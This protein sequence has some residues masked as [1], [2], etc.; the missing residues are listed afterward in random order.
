MAVESVRYCSVQ[1]IKVEKTFL[2]ALLTAGLALQ[3][4]AQ[5]NPAPARFAIVAEDPATRTAGDVLTAEL[6]KRTDLL[7]LE[8]SEIEKVYREQRL[9]AANTDCLKLGRILGADGLLVAAPV[10]EQENKVLELRLIAAKPGVVLTSERFPWPPADLTQWSAGVAGHLGA[11]LAK[12]SVPAREAVPISVVDFRSTV[13]TSEGRDAESQLTLLTIHRLSQEKKLFVLERRKMQLLAQE[14]EL[15]GLNEGT[16][17]NGS[18]LLEGTIDRDGYSPQTMTVSA[19]LIP[20][21]GG[22]PL[23]IELSG[24][25]T[26]IAGLVNQLTE[27]IL[28]NF[29]LHPPAPWQTADEAEQFASDAKWALRWGLLPQAQAAS[30]SA[31]ALGLRTKDVATMRI[32]AYADGVAGDNLQP[33]D[34][35][36]AELLK[37]LARALELYCDNTRRDFATTAPSDE[38]WYFMG[39]RVIRISLTMLDGFYNAAELRAGH[40]DELADVRALTRQAVSVQ[41]GLP[42]PSLNWDRFK[43][44]GALMNRYMFDL[45]AFDRV[46]WDGGGRMF[47]HPQDAPALFRTMLENGYAPQSLPGIIGWTWDDR[48]QVPKIIRQFIADL[49]AS[50]NV[51][52]KLQGLSL[53]LIKTPFYPETIFH[54]REGEL[55]SALW[56]NRAWFFSRPENRA[57]FGQIEGILQQADKYGNWDPTGRLQTQPFASLRQRLRKEFLTATTD[58]DHDF[59]ETLFGHDPYSIPPAEARELAPLLKAY[60]HTNLGDIAYFTRQLE[61]R[62][63]LVPEKATKAAPLSPMPAEEVVHARFIPWQLKSSETNYGLCPTPVQM[64]V[65]R[66]RLWARVCYLEPHQDAPIRAPTVYVSID[67]ASGDA[68]EFPFPDPTSFADTGFDVT[69]DSLYVSTGSGLH[70]YRFSRESWET[71][72]VPSEEDAQVAALNGRIYL[73]TSTALLEV[74]PDTQAVQILASSR[75]Q[76]ALN[77]VD[78]NWDAEA[79]IY[80]RTDGKMGALVASRFMSYDP[81]SRAWTQGSQLTKRGFGF[82]SSRNFSFSGDGAEAIF[83]AAP[84]TWFLLGYWNG[85]ATYDSLLEDHKPSPWKV[86]PALTKPFE[87]AR[88]DW[89]SHFELGSSRILADGQA[90]WILAPRHVETMLNIAT[91]PVAFSDNRN[92]TL[93]RFEPQFHAPLAVGVTFEAH[94]PVEDPFNPKQGGFGSDWFRY[95][96]SLCPMDHTVPWL[97]TSIGLVYGVPALTGHWLVPQARLQ[98]RLAVL[99]ANHRKEA[100]VREPDSAVQMANSPGGRLP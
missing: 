32:H 81:A 47:E 95:I 40:E 28:A 64:I 75:R 86:D 11:W 14:N 25:R 37:P 39:C 48:K 93:F 41:A 49:C 84:S 19:R 36:D 27:R 26:N 74:E 42:R 78:S 90:L 62:T 46:K 87:P 91:E 82:F 59:F 61:V 8:R 51:A 100:N 57:I 34:L 23:N 13:Q 12:L 77:S 7:L 69:D 5:L 71:I 63:G 65:H 24:S 53:A 70:R 66:D 45:E 80:A 73:A 67:P 72:P 16:F 92:A 38:G 50:T 76:P 2:I 54:Q 98:E 9:S 96:S 18:Y 60:R 89:P 88:W 99:R 58:Y 30:E 55:L 79:R 4:E 21:H 83:P 94:G 68:R 29:H 85:C 52:L 35:P 44:N 10:S 56:E 3:I 17:W 20:P 1:D 6:S 15:N 33:P 22:T 31:W 43:T 97:Q